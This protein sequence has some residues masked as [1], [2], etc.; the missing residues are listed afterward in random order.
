MLNVPKVSLKK[1]LASKYYYT[2]D[3]VLEDLPLSQLVCCSS[4]YSDFESLFNIFKD[5]LWDFNFWFQELLHSWL[6]WLHY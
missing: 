6:N 4:E 3:E 2:L 5:G 1:I